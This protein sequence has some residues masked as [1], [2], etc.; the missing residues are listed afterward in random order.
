MKIL[1]TSDWHLGQVLYGYDRTEEAAAMIAQIIRIVEDERPDV[2]LLC[3]DVYHSAQP[4]ATV[5][6]M[7]SEALAKIHDACPSMTMV[8]TAGNHDSPTKHEIFRTPWKVFNIHTIGSIDRDEP[9]N[10]LISIGDI[11]H[12]IAIPYVYERNLPEGFCQQILDLVPSDG[13]PIVMMGHATVRGCDYSGHEKATDYIVGG[14]EACE[15]TQFGQGYDY[16]ALGHIHH[17]QFIHT[18]HHNVRYS[19]SPLPVSFDENFEH[20]V[21]LVE[22]GS[23]G[24]RPEIKTLSISN[25]HPL[26]TLPSSGYATFEETKSLLK[27]FPDDIPAYIRLNVEVETA[28]PAGA[29][30][31]AVNL[32][33]GKTCR[34]SLINAKRKETAEGK[35]KT[36]TIS[37]LQCEQPIDIARDYA[38][39]QNKAFSK[40]L[41]LLFSLAVRQCEIDE[42]KD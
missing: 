33:K 27:D 21:S 13:L 4:S 14:I 42:R 22:I 25:P 19:G 28:L 34:F 10:N 2:F 37:E 18:G 5:Q 31:E 26:V 41:Q 24:E 29:N 7:F 16:L 20:T 35:A 32:C 30:D 9:S 38:K 11:G 6:T 39:S 17:G 23:R 36:L 8:I 1:H 3:G 15:L 12:I 40:E